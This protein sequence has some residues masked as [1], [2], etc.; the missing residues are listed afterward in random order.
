MTQRRFLHH[1]IAA[2]LLICALWPAAA[3]VSAAGPGVQTP[4]PDF[5]VLSG[6]GQSAALSDFLGKVLVIF[7]E[8]KDQVGVN[9]SLK[10]ALRRIYHP[11]YS[12]RLV[13]VDATS[14]GFFTEGIWKSRM[15][16]ASDREGLTI[17]G[18]WD[19]SMKEA[20]AM[21]E[22]S[23]N[24]LIVDKKGRVRFF[25]SGKVPDSQI[26]SI[27]QVLYRLATEDE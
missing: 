26:E 10:N 6:D 20:Y 8:D 18:D 19:G 15:C 14:A 7:Y 16:E 24:F 27:K 12:N 4:A 5:R 25:T 23:S 11:D 13:V 9:L 22:G 2:A 21:A 1:M 17:Y 3:P